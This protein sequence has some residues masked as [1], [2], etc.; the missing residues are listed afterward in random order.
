MSNEQGDGGCGHLVAEVA[1]LQAE[2]ARLQRENERLRQRIARLVQILRQ[3]R[4]VCQYHLV[5]TGQVLA[6]RSGIPRGNWAYAKGGYTVAASVWAV[7]R[8]GEG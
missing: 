6:H 4:Q 1:R 8:Q 7:L 2:V 5:R 3:A